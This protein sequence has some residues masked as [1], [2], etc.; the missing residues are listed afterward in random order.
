MKLLKISGAVRTAFAGAD[1]HIG[2]LGSYEFAEDSRKTGAFRRADVGIGPYN[3]SAN[4]YS[5]A[6]FGYSKATAIKFWG[7]V[8]GGA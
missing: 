2:P 1:A 8:A 4:S 6:N 5:L 7:T 3:V